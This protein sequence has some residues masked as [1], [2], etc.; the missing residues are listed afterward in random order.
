MQTFILPGEKE[1]TYSE[2]WLD[3]SPLGE[4]RLSPMCAMLKFEGVTRT[5]EEWYQ[6]SKVATLNSPDNLGSAV[7]RRVSDVY[8]GRHTRP[9]MIE[10][11]KVRVRCFEFKHP[12]IQD[13]VSSTET[14]FYL[15]LWQMYLSQNPEVREKLMG[16][17]GIRDLLNNLGRYHV[18]HVRTLSKI[19]LGVESLF[20]PEPWHCEEC[21][22]PKLI[23][24]ELDNTK[25]GNCGNELWEKS[26]GGDI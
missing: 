1:P 10:W 22:A 14:E 7:L 16:A 25:C 6:T 19:A 15:M 4:F 18:D 12:L 2:E 20:L 17:K 5:I 8:E 13:E 11:S 26:F 24:H 9:D 21:D 3:V 23:L